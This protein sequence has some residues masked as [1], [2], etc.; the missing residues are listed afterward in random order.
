MDQRACHLVGRREHRGHCVR[1]NRSQNNMS[2][3]TTVAESG[4]VMKPTASWVSLVHSSAAYTWRYTH[5]AYCDGHN[6]SDTAVFFKGAGVVLPRHLRLNM[7][8]TPTNKPIGS[9]SLLFISCCLRTH[10]QHK[11]SASLAI[12]ASK[13]SS[14]RSPEGT[15]HITSR[16]SRSPRVKKR[17]LYEMIFN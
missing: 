16:T 2:T 7:F 8:R 9:D 14:R 6:R 5:S 10:Q 11:C 3:S 4:T 12:G 17:N 15:P 1:Q 13:S